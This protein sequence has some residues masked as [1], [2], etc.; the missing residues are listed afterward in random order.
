MMA[1]VRKESPAVRRV[2]GWTLLGLLPL[3]GGCVTLFGKELGP[4]DPPPP[5]QVFQTLALWQPEV[6]FAADPT[7]NGAMIP[8]LAG[9][10]YLFGPD[11]AF[12]VTGDG[13]MIIDLY[14]ESA[15]QPV[16]LEQWRFDPVTLQRLLR[17]DI[18]GWGYTLFL[19][20]ST[21]KPEISKV[22]LKLRYDPAHGSPLFAESSAMTL[23]RAGST[24]P[25]VTTTSQSVQPPPLAPTSGPALPAPPPPA[26][27]A[28]PAPAMPAPPP[29][30]PA[31]PAPVAMPALMGIRNG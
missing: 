13:G 29:P 25:A 9:R 14:D 26:P 5:G 19:P 2:V 18:I 16:Q 23:N 3:A 12:P 4:N 20:W 11:I 22:H 27:V 31:M 17:R 10:V 28:M 30:A 24:M 15:G 21:Y 7:R 6:R 8:G 1:S